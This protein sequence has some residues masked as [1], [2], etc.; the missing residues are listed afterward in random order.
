VMR[1]AHAAGSVR[2]DHDCDLYG[3]ISS[4]LEIELKAGCFF[5]RLH[6]P[7]IAFGSA[8]ENSSPDAGLNFDVAAEPISSS[9]AAGRRLVDD[10]LDIPAGEVVKSSIVTRGALRIGAGARILGSAKS[11][12]HAAVESGVVVVGS[13]ISA[14]TMHVGADCQILGPVIAEQEMLIES[15]S[16]CG[17]FDKPTTVSAPVIEVEEG[18]VAFGTIWARQEGHVVPRK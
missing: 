4:D 5:Q 12:R 2:A 15:G 3:R 8:A 9:V 1:W 18:V 16:Q 7:R 10:D 14:S 13:L 17:T 6:A 11:N